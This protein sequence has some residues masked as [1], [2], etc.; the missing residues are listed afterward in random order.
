MIQSTTDVAHMNSPVQIQWRHNKD[1]GST[2][3]SFMDPDIWNLDEVEKDYLL[4]VT[5]N[6]LNTVY[7]ASDLDDLAVLKSQKNRHHSRSELTEMGLKAVFDRYPTPGGYVLNEFKEGEDARPSDFWLSRKQDGK[8]T[9]GSLNPDHS[10][11]KVYDL[12]DL[13][14]DPDGNLDVDLLNESFWAMQ[15]YLEERSGD[16]PVDWGSQ[17]AKVEGTAS[18]ISLIPEFDSLKF[19]PRDCGDLQSLEESVNAWC[20]NQSA[21]QNGPN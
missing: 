7:A 2:H 10:V 19:T 3:V 20:P 5:A 9:V 15:L 11:Y 14:R 16:K 18:L 13:N 6:A 17:T 4:Q 1:D 21:D 12:P 8:S